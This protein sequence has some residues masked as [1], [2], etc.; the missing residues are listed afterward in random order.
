MRYEELREKLN[1]VL[2]DA[3]PLRRM[4]LETLGRL[5]RRI[6]DYRQSAARLRS[7][8]RASAQLQTTGSGATS[9]SRAASPGTS[10]STGTPRTSSSS[11]CTAPGGG[12]S[13]RSRWTTPSTAGA[14]PGIL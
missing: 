12:W 10:T 2:A 7:L 13:A 5:H 1:Q 8:L 11:R 4:A 6:E 14:P 9:A 3:G